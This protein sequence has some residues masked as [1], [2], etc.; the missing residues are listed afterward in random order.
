LSNS[1]PKSVGSGKKTKTATIQA[2]A[3]KAMSQYIRQKYAKD[4][5]VTCVSCGVVIPWQEADC[6]HFIPKSRG[7]S[8]RYIEENCHPECKSCNR[9]DDGHLIGYTR[10]MLDMYGAEKI[11]ELKAES[12]K[13]LT[14]TAKRRLAEEAI[15]Y[16]RQALSQL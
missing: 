7:A 5:L 3:D 9:F 13:T 15:V 14:A 8:L 1:R 11:D 16:Y 12:R 10:H 2:T 4:G 6:G